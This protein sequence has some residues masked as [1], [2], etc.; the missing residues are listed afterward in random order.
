MDD[1][2]ITKN[3]GIRLYVPRWLGLIF[4]GLIPVAAIVVGF[5][6]YKTYAQPRLYNPQQQF[7]SLGTL[8]EKIAPDAPDS[9]IAEV[10]TD[11]MTKDTEGKLM[12]IFFYDGYVT[13]A[14]ANDTVNVLKET[15]KELE[16]F[17][18]MSD[19]VGYKVFTTDGKKCNVEK[20]QLVCDPKLIES[21]RKLGVEHFKVV[22]MS[23]EYFQSAAPLSRGTNSYIA[24]STFN[25][26]NLGK[27]DQRR[28]TGINFAQLL[29]HSLGLS[30]EMSDIESSNSAVIVPIAPPA[31]IP[32]K[33]ALQSGLPNCAT[34]LDTAKKWW[35]AY[36]ELFK[37]ISYNKNCEG[38]GNNY[39]PEKNTLMSNFPQ[40]QSYGLVSEDY[41]R[42]VLSCFYGGKEAIIFP[43]GFSATYSASFKSCDTFTKNYPN[44]WKE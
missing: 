3:P 33:T 32:Q 18:S 21:F 28:W 12:L 11:H 43:A 9:K 29:G 37:D 13:Q 20:N 2:Q 16:P 36:T 27:A 34:D 23:P 24:I 25:K 39:Y 7:E 15:L 35:G 17:K 10:I 31:G 40:K 14:E 1:H 6:L 41:L 38:N 42:G 19:L 22:L 26:T 8:G 44:F 30:Y 5:V 4:L